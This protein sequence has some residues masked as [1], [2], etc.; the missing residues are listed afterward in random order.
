MAVIFYGR[1]D[2]LS[3]NNQQYSDLKENLFDFKVKKYDFNKGEQ[4]RL[5][6]D[7][8][9]RKIDTVLKNS[10]G[11]EHEADLESFLGANKIPY[12]GSDTKT[13]FIGTS[14]FL[15]KQIFRLRHLPVV[16]DIF[17]DKIIWRKNKKKV[18]EKI[19]DKIGFPCL[20]KD[21]GGT[22][23]RGIYKIN[24]QAQVK[25]ALNRAVAVHAGVIVEKFICN[26][27]EVVCLA[28][29]NKNPKIYSPLGISNKSGQDIFSP[30]M[31]DIKKLI[32]FDV[33]ADLPQAIIRQIK[34]ITKSAHRALACRTF[35]RADILVADNKLNIL[36][37]D[38][39]TGFSNYSAATV[40]AKYEKQSINEL[41]LRFYKLSKV[42]L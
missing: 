34:E 21:V 31:K 25:E 15:S 17:V 38:V 3:A 4:N 8:K 7:F 27:Y 37:V 10:Y 1:A 19:V 6:N 20:I 5:L 36:E 23:S 30:K 2:Q 33:P 40:S 16:E 18:I 32:K 24:G 42:K 13:T 26:A 29:G 41:F 9:N 28:V 11:R 14:K 12:L 35:S 39:H 22:D